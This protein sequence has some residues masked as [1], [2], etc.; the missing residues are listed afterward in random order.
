[1]TTEQPRSP[2]QRKRD[3]LA[4]FDQDLDAW[5]ASADR[6]GNAHLVPLS[7][8]W[9]GTTFTLATDGSTPTGRNL[10]SSGRARLAIGLTRDVVLVDGTVETHTLDTVPTRLA[11]A[12][13]AKQAWDPRGGGPR[14]VFFLV[15]PRRIQAW[16]EVD[17]IAGRDLM[18]D[19]RWLV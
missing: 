14:Y 7:F 3:T 17:E 4:R 10:R 5:V 2:Q 11:D 8:L 12:F 9:D 13:A 15:T 1:M 19:G 16:R 18:R 6:D